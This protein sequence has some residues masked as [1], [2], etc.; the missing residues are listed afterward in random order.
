M[1]PKMYYKIL[2]VTICCSYSMNFIKF[3]FKE[4]LR[5][6]NIFEHVLFYRSFQSWFS[7]LNRN[8]WDNEAITSGVLMQVVDLCWPS[9]KGK[10]L[11]TIIIFITSAKEIN[12]NC[13]LYFN[14][15]YFAFIPYY[16]ELPW[17]NLDV[18]VM[19]SIYT[20]IA[21]QQN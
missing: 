15:I 10:T 1:R 16:V 19:S 7:M 8:A 9:V 18:L 11:G 21:N 3:V 2:F 6:S 12:N 4:F 13:A 14:V 20:S 5:Y 17:F